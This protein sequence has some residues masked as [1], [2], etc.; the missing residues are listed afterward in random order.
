MASGMDTPNNDGNSTAAWVMVSI[1]LVGFALLCL[2]FPLWSWTIG[3][4]GGVLVVAG[5]VVGK[6]MSQAGYGL[7]DAAGTDG[8]ADAP[9]MADA[10]ATGVN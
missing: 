9:D 7:A 8:L 5:L 2:A 6:V 1:M 3:I 10:D 4:I